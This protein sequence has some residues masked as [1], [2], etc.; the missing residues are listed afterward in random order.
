MLNDLY[1]LSLF[2]LGAAYNQNTKMPTHKNKHEQFRLS[3]SRF[4]GNIYKE[5]SLA[6]NSSRRLVSE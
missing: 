3:Q 4:I 2:G 6:G 5:M 1:T